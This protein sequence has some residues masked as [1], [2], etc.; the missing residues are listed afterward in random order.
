[1]ATWLGVLSPGP[2]LGEGPQAKELTLA[3]GL[4]AGAGH[5]QGG[6]SCEIVPDGRAEHQLGPHQ[7]AA[8]SAKSVP[9]FPETPTREH[10]VG[11]VGLSPWPESWPIC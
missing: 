2:T 3:P 7:R 10:P 9:G 8:R 5:L 11:S 4:A 1:M 6:L